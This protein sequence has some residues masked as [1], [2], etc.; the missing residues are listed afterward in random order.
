[1]LRMVIEIEIQIA[2]GVCGFSLDR[3]GGRSILWS[4]FCVKKSYGTF[5]FNLDGKLN[6]RIIRVQMCVE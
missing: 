5:C 2:V 3:K 6:V 4:C 1:M